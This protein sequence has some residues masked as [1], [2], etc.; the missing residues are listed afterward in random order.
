VLG[1]LD[2]QD[3]F[4]DT[5]IGRNV[6][7]ARHAL[8][9][10]ETRIDFEPTIITPRESDDVEQVWFAGAHAD[11]GGGHAPDEDGAR[12]SD[13]PLEW[14]MKEATKAGLTIETHLK[15]ELRPDARATLH[16]SRRKIYRLRREF[17][18]PLD[19]GKGAVAIHRSVRERWE[20][21]PDYRPPN[22][23]DYLEARGWPEP[24]VR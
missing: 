8:A 5:K 1:V 19:H 12:L 24:L 14:M 3:E 22:L 20:S 23:V 18:R 21:D 15:G 9:I 4:Y 16:P 6:E 17:E 13:L 11:V 2:A 10:D 7:R